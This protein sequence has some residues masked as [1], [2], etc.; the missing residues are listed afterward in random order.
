M[1]RRA[2]AKG[3][4]HSGRYWLDWLR[5][6][7]GSLRSP[8]L[9][10]FW[11]DEAG[12]RERSI[13]TRTADI[14]AARIQ[15]IKKDLTESGHGAFCPTCGQRLAAEAGYTLCDAIAD[16]LAIK[17]DKILDARLGHV[18]D[19]IETLERQDW[20]CSEIGEDWVAAFRTWSAAQ[21]VVFTS[22]RVRAEPRALSTTENSVIGLAAAINKAEARAKIAE[23][24]M[25]KT[26]PT[27]ELNNTPQKRLTVPEMAQAF[28]YAAN[29]VWTRRKALHRFLIGSV[30]TLGRPD[31]VLD[32]STVKERAQWNTNARIINL[33]QRGRRQTKKYRAILPAP[34]QLALHLDGCEGFFVP[35]KDISSAW[36]TMCDH[37]GWPKDGEHGPKLIRRSM[38][39]LLRDR[40]PKADWSEIEMF[41][42]HDKFDAT[43]DIYAPFDPDYLG[44]AR[45]EI[46][47][48]IDEIERLAPGAF[49]RSD[50]EQG[51]EVIPLSGARST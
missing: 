13:S 37:L 45:V 30:A 18:L 12:R 19:Y 35:V 22:G 14:E 50:A 41:L 2:K 24:A 32:I 34:W 21:P 10:I 43:S 40:L 26:I 46:E 4:H 15:L 9:Y 25:F 8:F 11:Y 39:K 16:Y 38:A 44:A 6:P 33:N 1:P 49:R 48:I 23:P 51:A 28:A 27:K 47:R 5:E 3:L 42:G 31:A 17:D 36:D 29:T 7:D 20:R